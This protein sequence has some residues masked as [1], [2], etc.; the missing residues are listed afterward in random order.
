MLDALMIAMYS[1]GLT[2]TSHIN[3]AAID[4]AQFNRIYPVSLGYE[5]CYRLKINFE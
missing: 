1:P 3:R 2:F 4:N 5:L